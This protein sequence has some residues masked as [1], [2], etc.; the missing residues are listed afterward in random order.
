MDTG[1]VDGTGATA[2]SNGA[3]AL[4]PGELVHVPGEGDVFVRHL[5]GPP[6]A[7]VIVLLHGW[8]TTADLNWHTS[9]DRLAEHFRVIAFDHRGHGRGLRSQAEGWLETCADDVVAVATALGVDRFIPV[10]YSMGGPIAKLVWRRHPHRVDGLVLCATSRHFAASAVRR[11]AFTLIDGTCVLT[12]TP[13]FRALGRLSG[14]AWIRRAQRRCTAPWMLE[15]ILHH[16][17]GHLLEAGR[18]IGRFDSRHWSGAIDVPTAV[19]ASLD[20]DVVPTRQQLALAGAVPGASL[21][22]V[23][24][25]HT[26]CA[27]PSGEFVARLLDACHSVAS[28]IT[29]GLGAAGGTGDGTVHRGA[30]TSPAAA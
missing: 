12:S 13:L 2:A 3:P 24:G 21:H 23:P 17:W 30:D 15:Q 25:G 4:P 27:D 7:P 26:A 19:V 20:D 6:G 22:T 5:P 18:A 14:P 1:R 9:Y 29:A 10:G 8:T 16:D 28:R 11:A